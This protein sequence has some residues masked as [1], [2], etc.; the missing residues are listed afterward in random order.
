MS[1]SRSSFSAMA[2]GER[3][4]AVAGMESVMLVRVDGG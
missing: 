2:E 3:M 4:D 1:T